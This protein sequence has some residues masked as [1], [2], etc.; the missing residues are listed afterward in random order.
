M[1]N[2]RIFYL[3]IF[4]FLLV[5]FSVCLNR[6]VFVMEKK[7]NNQ[8]KTYQC[9]QEEEQTNHDRQYTNL[10]QIHIQTSISFHKM[11]GLRSAFNVC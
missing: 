3:K 2:I 4:I 5:K 7:S 6:R 9:H 1:K 11:L 8:N 10:K